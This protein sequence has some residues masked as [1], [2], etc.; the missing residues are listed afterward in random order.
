M[1]EKVIKKKVGRPTKF[2]LELAKEI[3]DSVATSHLGLF[4]L[5]EQNPHW[6]HRSS[7]FLWLRLHKEFSDMY[8]KAKEDQT[9]V[10]VEYMQSLMNEPHKHYDKELGRTVCD[11]GMMRLKA[12]AIKWQTAK[13]KPRKYGDNYK[14]EIVNNDIHEDAMKRKQE[15]DEKYKKEF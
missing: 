3:C 1:V 15:M 10:C 8:T 5:C 11:V 12:D 14:E 7:I 4:D 6:P 9:E 2:N 13:L